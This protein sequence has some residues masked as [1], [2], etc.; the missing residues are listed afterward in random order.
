MTVEKSQSTFNMNANDVYT[1][2]ART[3]TAL[4]IQC[5]LH[6]KPMH[7]I[8]SNIASKKMK[9]SIQNIG[10]SQMVHN[11]SLSVAVN[12]KPNGTIH[13]QSANSIV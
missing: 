5:K 1:V 2:D 7:E 6:A 12:K 3:A 13:C 8:Q 10:L 4:S 11:N 9:R